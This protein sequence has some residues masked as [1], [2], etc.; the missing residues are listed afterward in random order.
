LAGLTVYR[1]ATDWSGRA[2]TVDAVVE[3][4]VAQRGPGRHQKERKMPETTNGLK[5]R[6]AQK[7]AEKSAASKELPVPNRCPASSYPT[8]ASQYGPDD[9]Y[10]CK[11]EKWHPDKR[12]VDDYGTV[13]TTEPNFKILA[14]RRP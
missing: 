13:W 10:R 6:L 8:K 7:L 4:I 14:N 11:K 1:E 3:R 9:V 12:H 5:E 2:E